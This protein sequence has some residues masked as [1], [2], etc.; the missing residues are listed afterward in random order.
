MQPNDEINLFELFETLWDGKWIIISTVICALS[1]GFVYTQILPTK[2]NIS[3][4][5]TFNLYSINAQLV[6]GDN[7]RCIE[8]EQTKIIS[9]LMGKNWVKTNRESNLY[10]TTQDPLSVRD[11]E[12]FFQQQMKKVTNSFLKEAQTELSLIETEQNSSLLKTEYYARNLFSAKRLINAIENGKLAVHFGSPK[13]T[14]LEVKSSLIFAMSILLGAMAGGLLV[15]ARSELRKYK[16]Q[17][18]PA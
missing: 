18:V 4:P 13:I 8:S 1:L 3:V 15:L 16:A 11:Y 9:T 2:Y 12:V 14:N 6:C 5:Y 17:I 7:V 10:M